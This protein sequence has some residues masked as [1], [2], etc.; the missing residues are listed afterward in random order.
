MNKNN[1]MNT[2][3]A[4]VLIGLGIFVI[5]SP[6]LIERYRQMEQDKLSAAFSA[7][8][9]LLGELEE[10]VQVPSADVGAGVPGDQSANA[11]SSP[12]VGDQNPPQAANKKINAESM[13]TIPS[14]DL[15]QPILSDATERH[16]SQSPSSIKGTGKPWTKGNY[17]IAGHRSRTFGRHFNRLG[18]L[19]VGDAAKIT[20]PKGKEYTYEIYKILIVDQ[21]ETYV[22]N[23]GEGKELT[24]ITCT[25]PGVKN[26][27]T[28]LVIKAKL[29][30]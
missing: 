20:D 7:D 29:K 24:L 25:P 9:A 23:N 11:E 13:L 8:L 10:P 3:I 16:L 14:I 6:T 15:E 5:L 27:K 28:R 12:S 26:P 4:T 22:M 2:L 21:S 30:T 19:K 17:V 1:K 18:E